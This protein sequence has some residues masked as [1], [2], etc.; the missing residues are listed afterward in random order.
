MDEV[1]ARI[2]AKQGTRP[3][4]GANGNG[5][6]ADLPINNKDLTETAKRLRDLFAQN[7]S[8][9]FN[10]N[11]PVRVVSEEGWAPV[12]KEVTA[13]VV[14]VAAHQLC[15]P[16]RSD[17]HGGLVPTTLPKTVAG[18][19]LKGL[20]GEWELPPFNGICCAPILSKDGSIRT[21]DG[22]D[23]ITGLWC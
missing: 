2:A 21:A 16:L 10:G 14:I 13:E 17:G 3:G 6:L 11:A 18:L 9:F 12:A 8:F 1:R 7:G 15:R 22:Y 19:Y 5:S 23:P 20:E 4:E